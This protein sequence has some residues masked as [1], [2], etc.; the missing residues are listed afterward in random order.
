MKRKFSTFLESLKGKDSGS[1]KL[2]E[3]INKAFQA[4]FEADDTSTYKRVIQ[5]IETLKQGSEL[6]SVDNNYD[7]SKYILPAHKGLPAMSIMPYNMTM[8]FR[9]Q[10][11]MD[12]KADTLIKI[13]KALKE[14]P[15][16]DIAQII[17]EIANEDYSKRTNWVTG[18]SM[19]K[20]K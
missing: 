10:S 5:H 12:G 4:C 7:F 1:D 9:G 13:R 2:I 3:S 8:T 18:D 16:E 19:R 17:N 15:N 20:L 14:D 11:Y 6:P